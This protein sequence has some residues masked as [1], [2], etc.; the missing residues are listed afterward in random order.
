[1][2]T[3][4][5]PGPVPTLD[6]MISLASYADLRQSVNLFHNISQRF[7]SADLTKTAPFTRTAG[8]PP[9]RLRL[10]VALRTRTPVYRGDAVRRYA[11][12]STAAYP[13]RWGA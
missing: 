3:V 8:C 4:R 11:S 5:R 7:C 6:A 13:R 12:A 10:P 9:N 2:S 1:M